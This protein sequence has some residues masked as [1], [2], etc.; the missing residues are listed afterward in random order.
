MHLRYSRDFPQSHSS[1]TEALH[2]RLPTCICTPSSLHC[3]LLCWHSTSQTCK[4]PKEDK[5]TAAITWKKKKEGK[6]VGGD[7]GEAEVAAVQFV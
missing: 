4:V 3:F 6:E 5:A 2:L 7:G 1:S